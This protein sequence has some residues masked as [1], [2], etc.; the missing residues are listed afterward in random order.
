MKLILSEPAIHGVVLGAGLLEILSS[1]ALASWDVLVKVLGTLMVFWAAHVYAGTVAH[2]DDE[3]EG[4]TPARVRVV[5][6]ARVSI[7]HSWGLL[8]AGVIPLI[9]LTVGALGLVTDRNAIWGTLWLAVV[10]LGVLGWLGVSS[11]TR[12]TRSRVLGALTTA[13]R[14][15]GI[16]ALKACVK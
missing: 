1:E 3:Y 5:R 6:A 8:L 14:G 11:W 13:T 12:D 9:V 10:V 4:D 15:L 2:L 7:D 16:V